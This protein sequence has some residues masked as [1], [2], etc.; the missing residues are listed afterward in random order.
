MDALSAQQILGLFG[1]NIFVVIVTAVGVA[2][3]FA[4]LATGLRVLEKQSDKQ[5]GKIELLER[6]LA[7]SR[8]SHRL[9]ERDIG[10]IEAQI[11]KLDKDVH[12]AHAACRDVSTLV[13]HMISTDSRK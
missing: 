12:A 2:V 7:D 10:R 8:T 3:R 4:N 5:D 9:S 1:L 11:E 6:E 13:D